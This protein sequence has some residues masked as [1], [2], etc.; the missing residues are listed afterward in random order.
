MTAPLTQDG[1]LEF[2]VGHIRG[3]MEIDALSIREI[4][5][6]QNDSLTNF[7]EGVESR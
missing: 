5:D 6:R 1:R 7:I 3:V 4:T 2:G